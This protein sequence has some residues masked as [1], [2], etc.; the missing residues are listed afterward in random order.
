MTEKKTY[1]PETRTIRVSKMPDILILRSKDGSVFVDEQH[2]DGGL[3][4]CSGLQDALDY[5]K[6]THHIRRV[7][8]DMYQFQTDLDNVKFHNER[9]G[10]GSPRAE[11]EKREAN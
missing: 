1:P 7:V 6:R 11:R 4:G 2:S 10:P 3:V 8:I 9:K 5:C